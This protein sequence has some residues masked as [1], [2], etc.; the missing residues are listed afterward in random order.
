MED[1]VAFKFA[2]CTQPPDKYATDGVGSP[3]AGEQP[4]YFYHRLRKIG[5]KQLVTYHHHLMDIKQ[6]IPNVK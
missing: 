4:L 3:G 1:A 2:L 5:V 6:E